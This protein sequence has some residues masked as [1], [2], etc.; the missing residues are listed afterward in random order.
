MKNNRRISRFSGYK[1]KLKKL[2]KDRRLIASDNSLKDDIRIKDD[3]NAEAMTLKDYVA[4]VLAL[5]SLFLPW[6]L[7]FSGIYALVIFLLT[8]FWLK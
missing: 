1:E 4:L 7:I 5:L 3:E 8:K 2:I 6:A